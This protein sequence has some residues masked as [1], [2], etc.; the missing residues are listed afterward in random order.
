MALLE[1]AWRS[2]KGDRRPTPKSAWPTVDPIPGRV[3]LNGPGSGSFLVVLGAT[4]RLRVHAAGHDP[5]RR[6]CEA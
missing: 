4:P 5:K 1:V 6:M 3:E 2:L